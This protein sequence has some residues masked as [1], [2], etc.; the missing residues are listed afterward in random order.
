[1]SVAVDY[2]AVLD[3]ARTADDEQ[4]TDAIKVSMRRWRKR[5]EASELSVRQE[6]ENNIKWIQEARETLLNPN[7]RQQYDTQLA[8][9]GV[10]KTDNTGT[11]AGNWL[12]QAKDHLARGDYHSAAYAA[13]EATHSTGSSAESWWIRS[14]ANAGLGRL[15]D[16]LYE[17]QQSVQIEQANPAYHFHLGCLNEEA[18]RWASALSEF[19]TASQLDPGNPL[20]Q[21]AIG[22]VYLSNGLP[23][24]ALPI[25]EP[26]YR[27]HPD[28]ETAGFYMASVL[29]DLAEQV[30]KIKSEASYVVTSAEEI[31]TMRGY[32]RRAGA[33]KGLPPELR[34]AITHITTYLDKMESKK[35]SPPIPALAPTSCLGV[36][37]FV[38][39]L[40]SPVWLVIA[41]IGAVSG[42]DSVAGGLFMIALGLG[43]GYLWFRL[44][45][46]PNWKISARAH[47]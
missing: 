39:V 27:A 19:Q 32:V 40:L 24:K 22:S 23:A 1:M 4:I 14:R 11:A 44:S 8:S 46:V 16:A 31:A 29:I 15:D 34:Q 9:G 7:R 18:E 6:A 47:R 17:A 45:W 33:I 43:L 25:I 20:Y 12:E 41:G 30:P 35:F 28:D 42:G 3:V 2:Y 21:L 13:R 37:L 38:A 36:V 26:V 10:T 5:A